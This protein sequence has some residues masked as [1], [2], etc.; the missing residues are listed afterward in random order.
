[1]STREHQIYN[2]AEVDQKAKNTETCCHSGSNERPSASDGV[3]N[4]QVVILFTQPLHSGRI[5]H[6]VNFF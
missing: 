2:I 3:Q 1:M 5:W 4:S 6:K